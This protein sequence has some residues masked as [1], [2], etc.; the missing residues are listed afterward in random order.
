MAP[1]IHMAHGGGMCQLQ[2][3]VDCLFG[4]PGPSY[5]MAVFYRL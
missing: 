5:E 2:F 1:L 3:F 4:E